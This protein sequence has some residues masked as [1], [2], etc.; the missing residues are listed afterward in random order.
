[1]VLLGKNRDYISIIA[2]ILEVAKGG[3]SKTHIMYGANLSFNLLEKYLG[4]ALESG[5]IR[6]EDFKYHLTQS[7]QEYLKQYFKYHL[8][9]SGQE[10]L[11]Q[12][13]HFETRYTG[14]QKTLESLSCERERFARFCKGSKENGSVRSFVDAE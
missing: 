3:S 6:H 10:Y 12:Y 4:V 9:Q 2:A 7:G 13:K 14:A 5:F 8:T 1:V 11:K